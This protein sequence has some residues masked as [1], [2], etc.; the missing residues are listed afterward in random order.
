MY[1]LLAMI[2]DYSSRLSPYDLQQKR[3]TRMT[4]V[5]LILALQI[6][7]AYAD[8]VAIPPAG[9]NKQTVTNSAEGNLGIGLI[10]YYPFH[11]DSRDSIRENGQ[12]TVTHA[13]LT[14]DRFGKEKSAYQFDGVRSAMW[15]KVQFIPAY[16]SPQ[17]FSWWYFTKEHQTYELEN[18]AGNMI[19]VADAEKGTGLQFGFR[20]PGYNTLGLDTWLWGGGTLLEAKPPAVNAWHHC[21]Y[22]CDGKTNRFYLD[23]IAVAAS[24]ITPQDGSPTQLMLGNYPA[25]DQFFRGKLDDIRIYDRTLSRLE[26]DLL[27]QE[28]Q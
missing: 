27:F 20:A 11:G 18:G 17:S 8:K 9:P 22:S 2:Q 6:S 19:A 25:G 5:A 26:I 15:S 10:A 12:L 24:R 28:T 7:N 4:I 14:T 16:R 3:F 1:H 21:A 13:T 23:G